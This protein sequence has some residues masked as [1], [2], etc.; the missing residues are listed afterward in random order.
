M[1][2]KTTVLFTRIVL[3]IHDSKRKPWCMYIYVKKPSIL[4]HNLVSKLH[5]TMS[6]YRTNLPIQEL[7]SLVSVIFLLLPT[8]LN[9]VQALSFNFPKLTPGDSRITLQGDA[10]I[11]ASG[12]LA[13]TT[14]SRYI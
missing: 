6:F 7:F 14:S 2:I 13:L 5:T 8:N 11:L 9:S 4:I 1:L 10:E 3:I 12:V